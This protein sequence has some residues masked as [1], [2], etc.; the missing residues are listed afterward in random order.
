MA[1]CLQSS[2]WLCSSYSSQSA[3]EVVGLHHGQRQ[4]MAT[5]ALV[6]RAL[7]HTFTSIFFLV[8]SL[9][10]AAPANNSHITFGIDS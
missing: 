6:L 2:F 5:Q 4:D 7:Y 8:L 9:L 10:A 1:S 3:A